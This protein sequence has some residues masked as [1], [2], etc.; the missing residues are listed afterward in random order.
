MIFFSL[1]APRQRETLRGTCS[2]EWWSLS[3]LLAGQAKID[4][5]A[6]HSNANE[7]LIGLAYPADDRT[8]PGFLK[9]RPQADAVG[10]NVVMVCR[11]E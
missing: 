4:R 6:S 7:L 10:I 9:A 3:I 1:C 11:G 5:A 2:S 8:E